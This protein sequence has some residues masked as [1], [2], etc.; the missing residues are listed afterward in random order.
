[1]PVHDLAVKV[2]TRLRVLAERALGQQTFE[3]LAAFGINLWIVNIDRRRQ[4]NFRFA[5]MQETAW[6]IFGRVAGFRGGHD[7]VRQFTDIRRPIGARTQSGKRFNLSHKKLRRLDFEVGFNPVSF[8]GDFDVYFF[9]GDQGI[10][11]DALGEKNAGA[12]GAAGANGRLAADDGGIRVNGD[13]VFDGGVALL[14]LEQLPASQGT[15]HQADA[16]IH[17]YMFAND[18]GF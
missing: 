15:S 16:L 4:I 10:G 13:G 9:V 1:M 14:A 6:I 2:E 17:F 8:T 12:N 7:V 11:R 5:D 3:V 18:S